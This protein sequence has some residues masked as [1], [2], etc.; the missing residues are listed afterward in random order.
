E[1]AAGLVEA[2]LD[3]LLAPFLVGHVSAKVFERADCGGCGL[4]RRLL[5]NLRLALP[6]KE[7]AALALQ[8]FH[9]GDGGLEVVVGLLRI[10]RPQADSA[11]DQQDRKHA[12]HDSSS[13]LPDSTA[14]S[15]CMAKRRRKASQNCSGQS[16]RFLAYP[17]SFKPRFRSARPVGRDVCPSRIRKRF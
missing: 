3:E 7:T 16:T 13:G 1:P 15:R 9:V 5:A 6:G 11:Q 14:F 10:R 12:P 2:A 17:P 8:L 4:E